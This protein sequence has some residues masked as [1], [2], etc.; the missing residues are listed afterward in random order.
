MEIRRCENL[1]EL[2]DF[3]AYVIV[4]CPNRFPRRERPMNLE[5]AFEEMRHGMNCLETELQDPQSVER[6]R[7]L[8]DD[9]YSDFKAG[10]DIEGSHRLQDL[11]EFLEGL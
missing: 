1:E 5:I 4:Y 9:A 11:S 10:H 2:I 7:S 3:V 8:L 6:A